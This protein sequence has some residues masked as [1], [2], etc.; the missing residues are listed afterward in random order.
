M[1]DKCVS[2]IEWPQ[3]LHSNDYP[4][5]YL[6]IEMLINNSNQNRIINIKPVGKKWEEKIID[7]G[8]PSLKSS[9]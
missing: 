8:L 6:D 3:R 5:S 1:Y 2:I 4:S 7:I 9:T